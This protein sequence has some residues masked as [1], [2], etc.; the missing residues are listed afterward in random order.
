MV[1][2]WPGLSCKRETRKVVTLSDKA[3][4]IP[5]SFAPILRE[6]LPK[7]GLHRAGWIIACLAQ[8]V[9]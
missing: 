5:D 2:E 1:R 3:P 4:H 7:R 8:S 6:V 9:R